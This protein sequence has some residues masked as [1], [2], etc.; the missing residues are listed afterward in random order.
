MKRLKKLNQLLKI[1]KFSLVILFALLISLGLIVFN[2]INK[3]SFESKLLGFWN[4][5][6][7]NSFIYR[8]SLSEFKGM[9]IEFSEN[10]VIN[11][12][13]ISQELDMDFKGKT[14]LDNVFDD[15]EI[16]LK[17]IKHTEEMFEKAIGTWRVLSINPDSIYINVPENPLHGKYAVRFFIDESGYMDMVN[18]IYK[19]ELKN[20]STYLICNKGGVIFKNKTKNWTY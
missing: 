6:Y 15:E 8:D 19:I 14:F 17:Y 18:N 11:L 13:H 1:N 2:K 5:E 3:P 4:I 12:P 16:R 7:D 10:N 20:D 9:I